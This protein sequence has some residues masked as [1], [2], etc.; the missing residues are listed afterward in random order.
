M[1]D[2]SSP[3][4]IVMP[5]N[6]GIHQL[7]DKPL[8]SRFRGSD[9][10]IPANAGIHHWARIR[11]KTCRPFLHLLFLKSFPIEQRRE[12]SFI[13]KMNDGMVQ[14]LLTARLYMSFALTNQGQGKEERMKKLLT[15]ACMTT[16]LAVAAPVSAG[17][18]PVTDSLT[19]NLLI[20]GLN[21]SDGAFTITA[22]NLVGDVNFVALPETQLK[23]VY[24]KG[25]LDLYAPLPLP[26]TAPIFSVTSAGFMNIFKGMLGIPDPGLS[27]MEIIPLSFGPL[28]TQTGFGSFDIVYDGFTSNAFITAINNSIGTMLVN[29]QGSGVVTVDYTYNGNSVN[30]EISETFADW[31]GFER[32]LDLAGAYLRESIVDALSPPLNAMVPPYTGIIAGGFSLTNAEIKFVPEPGSLALFG[33]GMAGLAAAGMRRRRV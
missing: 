25:E 5:A 11:P 15:A 28:S 20:S 32:L 13:F 4:C 24:V 10:V 9:G 8:D 18:I 27:G 19:G 30:L 22:T 14:I 31:M 7:R 16:A 33:L 3:S 26:Q 12:N 2:E 17:W 23:G 1:V 21:D 6:A 29:T